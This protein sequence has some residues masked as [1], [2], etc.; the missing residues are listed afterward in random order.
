MWKRRLKPC[1]SQKQSIKHHNPINFVRNGV[2]PPRPTFSA[3]RPSAANGR[4]QSD[5]AG[6][7]YWAVTNWVTLGSGASE[8]WSWT[9]QIWPGE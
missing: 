1:V 5:E 2:P 7:Y 9:N 6:N 4:I 8:S 3:S